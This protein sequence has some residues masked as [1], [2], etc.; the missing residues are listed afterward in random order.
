MDD[1]NSNK[2]PKSLLVICLNSQLYGRALD[3]CKGIQ[4]DEIVSKHGVQNI[5]DIVYNRDALSVVTKVYQDF[6][7]LLST[8]RENNE[9][10]HN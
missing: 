1:N 4:G 8:P 3:L 6:T 10:C 7:L 5:L 2:I 9:S